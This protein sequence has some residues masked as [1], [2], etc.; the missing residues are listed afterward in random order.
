VQ[1]QWLHAA[2]A[3]STARYRIVLLHHP[4]FSSGQ[5][6]SSPTVQWPFREW[7]ATAVL[8]GHDHD[9]ERIDR[10][11]MPYVVVGTGGR[12]LY[13][14]TSLAGGSQ[15]RLGKQHGALLIEVCEGRASAR[16]ATSDGVVLDSFALPAAGDLPVATSLIPASARWKYLA[17]GS[18]PGETWR[19]HEFDDSGWTVTGSRAAAAPSSQI[20]R[21]DYTKAPKVPFT[22]SFLRRRFEVADP[23]AFGWIELALPPDDEVVANLNGVEVARAAHLREPGRSATLSHLL[24]DP[25]ALV[26]GANLVAVELR[27][28]G[29]SEDPAGFEAELVGYSPTSE[30]VGVGAAWRH[31]DGGGTPPPGWEKAGF[32]DSAWSRDAAPLPVSG[33]IRLRGGFNVAPGSGFR[34]LLLHVARAGAG[35]AYLNRTEVAR[36]NLPD[37][38]VGLLATPGDVADLESGPVEI[39]VAADLLADGGNVL[40]IELQ[41]RGGAE[42]TLSFDLAL[43]GVR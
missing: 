12:R 7:G 38:D 1:A 3:E 28:R 30:L 27:H 25:S 9:Y 13:G 19:T 35:V 15:V 41:P 26:A 37:P 39:L 5:H 33:P 22:S 20:S 17:G 40:A 11:G 23:N 4:P 18:V 42:S 14:F 32:D 36:W 34:E 31:Q 43:R 10:A 8:A 29:A 2:L 6:H 21:I 24:I 16:F